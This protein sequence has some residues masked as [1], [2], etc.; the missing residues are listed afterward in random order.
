VK[1]VNLA[2]LDDHA[3]PAPRVQATGH[4]FAA[5]WYVLRKAP[6]IRRAPLRIH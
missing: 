3:D 4:G 5:A 2:P 6:V 1:W